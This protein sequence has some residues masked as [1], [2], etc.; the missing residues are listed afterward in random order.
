ME[1]VGKEIPKTALIIHADVTVLV[2][3]PK[4]RRIPETMVFVECFCSVYV[5]FRTHKKSLEGSLNCFR[6]R[7]VSTQ[8]VQNM[9]YML[10]KIARAS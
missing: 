5:V 9:E 7:N 2:L 8:H 4:T 10:R 3:Q 6:S 1:Y